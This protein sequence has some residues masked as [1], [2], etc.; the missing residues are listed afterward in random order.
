M[1]AA[2]LFKSGRVPATL[3]VLSLLH[4]TLPTVASA[5]AIPGRAPEGARQRGEGKALPALSLSAAYTATGAVTLSVD[6]V[7]V[8]GRSG[9]LQAEKPAGGS[10]RAAFLAAASTGFTNAV[11]PD[12]T[13][14][15]NALPVSW[16]RALINTIGSRNYWA[17]V[18][19]LAA[20]ALDA[21][22]P[23]LV[24]L[25]VDEGMQSHLIDGTI[26]AVVWDD[27][28]RAEAQTI[29]L[30]F[31]AQ[32]VDGDAFNIGLAEP[33]EPGDP[34]ERLL[35]SLGISFG[36]Q[37]PATRD[38]ASRVEVNG[39]RVSSAA[40]GQD[41][42]EPANGALL[43]VGGLGDS[44]DVPSDPEAPPADF[45]SDD[46]LYDLKPFLKEGTPLIRITTVNPSRDDNIFFAA[47]V[48]SGVAVV[49][50][51]IVLSPV[52]GTA[53]VGTAQE[54][55]ALVQDADGARLPGRPVTFLVTSGP[56]AGLTETR[57]TDVDGEA[58]LSLPG[59]TAGTDAIE[60]RFVNAGGLTVTSNR[61]TRRWTVDAA[62]PE[63]PPDPGPEAIAGQPY[64]IDVPF[65]NCGPVDAEFE[66][67]V[68][69]TMGWLTGPP[70]GGRLGAGAC[71]TITASGVVPM[72][73]A[74]VDTNRV[75]FSVW[76][77]ADPAAAAGCAVRV[78]IRPPS[79]AVLLERFEAR[80]ESGGVRLTWETALENAH[81]W[82]DLYRAEPDG[83]DF[84]R[85]NATPLDEPG[86]G[87]YFD[88]TAPSDVPC[89]YR[90]EAVDRAGVR[91]VAG[92]TE[93]PVGTP[94]P[95]LAQ[96]LPNPF[97]AE[98]VFRLVFEQAGAARFEI[99]DVSGRRVR[100]L[101]DGTA[102]PG[103][104]ELTWDGRDDA[105]RTVTAGLY[106]ARLADGRGTRSVR[107]VHAPR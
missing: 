73:L 38:Q 22:A 87:E 5:T 61:V 54:V 37:D 67:R 59:E 95:P 102:Q 75:T 2:A 34:D 100:L 83:G 76:P 6:G 80:R 77:A 91:Q 48:V 20:P 85:L 49:N 42:G 107:L 66:W 57:V 72:K 3:A 74:A 1:R 105:G 81:A 50:E 92:E 104:T 56:H 58:I 78:P 103:S 10:V 62:C 31:G 43:T 15:L 25:F 64:S 55:T 79:L 13:V 44:P 23:G 29:S 45:D 89:R 16:E 90:L 101:F 36:F 9:I 69:D 8:S 39:S 97:A 68:T 96:N 82:F 86:Q 11:I 4:L 19:A 65:C 27:P 32:D 53:P 98:T 35:L 63:C 26:L 52:E 18:T 12:G 33:V 93:A 51:G 84:V 14:T 40:G 94:A 46:E 99:F 88:A 30:F 71:T 7:G 60:A 70:E 47:F 28:A 17:D 106:F 24:S 21:A 41:D